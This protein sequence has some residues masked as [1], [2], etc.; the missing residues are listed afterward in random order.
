MANSALQVAVKLSLQAQGFIQSARE[1]IQKALEIRE[2]LGDA[3]RSMDGASGSS[4]Q[5]SKSIDSQ[6][7]SFSGLKTTIMGLATAYLSFQAVQSMATDIIKT[8]AEAQQL[9]G[10]IKALTAS[11]QEY[12]ETQTY[13]EKA[14]G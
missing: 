14:A 5:L 2:S 7:T 11:S 13:I 4:S 8:V 3:G 9:Q 6:S 10:R 12:A 1:S